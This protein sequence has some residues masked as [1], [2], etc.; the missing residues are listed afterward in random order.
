MDFDELDIDKLK[1]VP[2]DLSKLNNEV[3][4]DVVKQTEYNKLLTKI[5]TIN[6]FG[7]ILKSQY[8]TDKSGLKSKISNNDKNIP[9]SGGLARKQKSLRLKIKA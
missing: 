3:D 2:I 9:D 5:N 7:F 6:T 4:N 1:T 8:N